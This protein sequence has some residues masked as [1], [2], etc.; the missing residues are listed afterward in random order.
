MHRKLTHNGMEPTKNS[1]IGNLLMRQKIF[2]HDKCII[3]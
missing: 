3:G 2:I 1:I